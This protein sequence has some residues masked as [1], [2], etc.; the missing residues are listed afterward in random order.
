[1]Y[2][3]TSSPSSVPVILYIC[4][5]THI[6]FTSHLFVNFGNNHPLFLFGSMVDLVG[7]RFLSSDSFNNFDHSLCSF[8]VYSSSPD[9]HRIFD[10]D[11]FFFFTCSETKSY[12]S[13]YCLSLN[14]PFKTPKCQRK[15]AKNETQLNT[16]K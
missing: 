11:F 1:M 9:K 8:C 13:K 10:I 16:S 14:S 4:I 5:F 6:S 15:Y 12:Y 7:I 2:H 3:S